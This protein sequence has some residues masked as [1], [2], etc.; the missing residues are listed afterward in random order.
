MRNPACAATVAPPSGRR[1][2]AG[3]RRRRLQQ[4]RLARSQVRGCRVFPLC[5]VGARVVWPGVKRRARGV[6]R[7][8]ASAHRSGAPRGFSVQWPAGC[9]AAR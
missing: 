9:R 3:W 1:G 2:R 6:V 5:R 8:V 7:G 4:Q